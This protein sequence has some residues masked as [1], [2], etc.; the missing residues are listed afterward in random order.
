MRVLTLHEI[1][2]VSGG[3]SL[4]YPTLLLG[5]ILVSGASAYATMIKIK[6]NFLTYSGAQT[7]VNI[8]TFPLFGM[9]IGAVAMTGMGAVAGY[10][11]YHIIEAI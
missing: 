5:Q 4:F 8:I 1:E 9:P 10:Y 11:A 2:E 7:I 3:V 6:T